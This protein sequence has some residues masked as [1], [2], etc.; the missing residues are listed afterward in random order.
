MVDNGEER[1]SGRACPGAAVYGGTREPVGGGK[2]TEHFGTHLGPN[3][4]WAL[5]STHMMIQW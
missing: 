2:G 5:F 3:V 4:L 1:E